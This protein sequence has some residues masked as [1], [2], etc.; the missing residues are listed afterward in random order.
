MSNFKIQGGKAPPGR[1]CDT[2]GLLVLGML[3]QGTQSERKQ[4]VAS[5]PDFYSFLIKII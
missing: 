3:S 2:H 4:V 5:K 1:P